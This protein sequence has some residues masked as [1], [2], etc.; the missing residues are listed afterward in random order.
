MA[1]ESLQLLILSFFFY[2]NISAAEL[3]AVQDTVSQV[4]TVELA[5]EHVLPSPYMVIPFIV[6]LLM[7]ATGPLFY[8]HF[9]ERH[10]PKMAI[11]LGLLLYSITL[12]F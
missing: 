1:A 3:P 4:R 6:L 11:L 7:I 9:W 2:C 10:Y 5:G 12:S 8:K